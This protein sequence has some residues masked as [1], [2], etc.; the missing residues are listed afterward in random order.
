[1]KNLVLA[2]LL[3]LIA[4]YGVAAT[5]K[6]QNSS[7]DTVIV[8]LFN[9]NGEAVTSRMIDTTTPHTLN[10]GLH[11]IKKVTWV[12]AKIAESSNSSAIIGS[13]RKSH[14][15]ST[16]SLPLDIGTL[17]IGQKLIILKNGNYKYH[18]KKNETK[19]GTARTLSEIARENKDLLTDAHNSNN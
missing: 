13:I 17:S 11:S 18:P 9:D 19:Q 3:T 2:A 12:Q 14:D 15:E 16:Y 7:N 5:L 10:S 4:H 8:T 6:V 1:M